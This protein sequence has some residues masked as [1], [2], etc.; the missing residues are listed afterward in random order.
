MS[1]KLLG[2]V[3]LIVF[4]A[5]IGRRVYRNWGLRTGRFKICPHC[6]GYYRGDPIYCPH[7]GEVLKSWSKR[8]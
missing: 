5:F 7:C 4:G 3:L 2:V 1:L 8:R 6:G